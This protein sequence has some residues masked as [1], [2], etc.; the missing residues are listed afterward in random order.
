MD[1]GRNNKGINGKDA[2]AENMVSEKPVG[3]R[4]VIQNEKQVLIPSRKISVFISSKCGEQAPAKYD[5]VRKG[6]KAAIE[7]TNF[8]KVYAFEQTGSSTLT[9]ETHFS[10]ALEEIDVCIF[11]IDNKDGVTTGVQKEIEIAKK[12]KIKTLFYFCDENTKTKTKLEE[13]LIGAEFCKSST[14]HSFEDLIEAGAQDFIDDV[15]QIYHYYC[16]NKL[17]QINNH[18]ES[19]Q[20][21]D[22]EATSKYFS[23]VIPTTVL[24][25]I[26]K[27]RNYISK[28][29]LNQPIIYYRGEMEK[30]SELDGLCLS[31]LPV[32]FEG[33]IIKQFNVIQ[34]LSVLENLQ[35]RQYY[36][37]VKCRWMAIE[38]YYSDD[39]EGCIKQ[40]QTTLKIAKQKKQPQWV[41]KDLLID[42]RNVQLHNNSIHNKFVVQD[43]EEQKEL[44]ESNENIYYPLLDRILE[45]VYEKYIEDLYQE[46]LRLPH[47][48]TFGNIFYSYGKLLASAFVVSMFNG[49]LTH[50]LL[51]VRKIRDFQ[52]FLSRKYDYWYLKRDLLKFAVYFRKE[53]DIRSL[54][55]LC[56]E[57]LANLTSDDACLI[58]EF[59]NNHPVRQERFISQLLA[60]GTVGFYLTDKDFERYK[61]V[62]FG[63]IKKW[64]RNENRNIDAGTYIFKCI[65][66]ISFR[67]KQDEIA[68]IFI[69]FIKF[70]IRRYYGDLF[71]CIAN[72]IK[73]KNMRG[74]VVKQFLKYIVAVLEDDESLPIVKR[75]QCFLAALRK[76]N[77]D[78]T[79]EVNAKIEQYLPEYFSGEYR[80]ETTRN[81]QEDYSDFAHRYVQDVRNAN[82]EQGKNGIYSLSRVCGIEVLR[83]ILMD[84]EFICREE[85]LAEIVET[86]VDTLIKSKQD[87]STKLDAISLLICIIH[88]YPIFKEKNIF[89]F[90]RVINN[91]ESIEAYNDP[92]FS[93]NINLISI[94]IAIQLLKIAM[95]MDV[96]QEFLELMPYIQNDKATTRK[97]TELFVNYLEADKETR[98]PS[99]IDTLVLQNVLQWL[100]SEYLI[101]R[102]N[103]TRLLLMMTR[104]KENLGLVNRKL[105]NLIDNDSYYIKNLVLR[106]M[107]NYEGITKETKEY[108]FAKCSN[109]YNFAVRLVCEE[110]KNT[111]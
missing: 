47:S 23:P 40:L 82:V 33:K 51:F 69:L 25:S 24:N 97:I 28:L 86:A 79:E 64:I 37:I 50:L 17:V 49:S 53:K 56:P 66:D 75:K 76:Q 104:N 62:V 4:K 94:K 60:L 42:I 90:E 87:L 1:V 10:W 71:G 39:L 100:N 41:I 34:L 36:K 44:I 96:Y 98:L 52:F 70:N 7:Q 43:T 68:E 83:R 109:D 57:V 18:E 13:S 26:D 59:C 106:Q 63:K 46:S 48:V 89:C 11:L 108:I 61:N 8:A 14:V 3:M 110:V 19:V 35:E 107:G 16:R 54:K 12:N 80:L 5:K 91:Q 84:D 65:E 105:L 102:W 22:I 55:E 21:V 103:A 78:L 45:D 32:L 27:C 81:K 72:S 101:I 58:M 6:L 38:K 15:T 9:A 2:I 92:L 73:L 31:F 77:Y 74:S 88:K 111:I 29:T 99:K 93:S 85:L 95:G 20:S 67:L 30:T